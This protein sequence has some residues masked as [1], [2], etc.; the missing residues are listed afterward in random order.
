[1]AVELVIIFH[2]AEDTIMLWQI[3]FLH[4]A[5]TNAKQQHFMI[6]L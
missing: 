5:G 2:Y 6:V 3:I 4:V 1:M